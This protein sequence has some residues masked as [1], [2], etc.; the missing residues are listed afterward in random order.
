MTRKVL[1]GVSVIIGEQMV[2]VDG[3]MW[4][5]G[6]GALV[7]C[8]VCCEGLLVLGS[9]NNE[10]CEVKITPL[11]HHIPIHLIT[12]PLPYHNVVISISSVH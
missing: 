1:V 4:R 12:T 3:G 7:E 6:G 8:G 5:G 9:D 11:P 10:P 2:H